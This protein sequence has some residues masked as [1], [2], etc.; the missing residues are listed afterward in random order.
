[1]F[2]YVWLVLIFLLG[3]C[4]GS[5]LNVCIFRLPWEKNVLWPG[6]HCGSCFQAI[7]WYDNLPILSWLLLRG[8]CRRCGAPFSFRYLFIELFTGLSFSGMFYLIAIVN[9]HDFQQ[10]QN[11]AWSLGNGWPPPA[12][13]WV[14]FFH[15]AC[16]ISFLIVASFC[17]LDHQE[18]PF[19]I[20]I[21]G[22]A[23]GLVWAVFL[24]WP[25]PYA[26]E[27]PPRGNLPPWWSAPVQRPLAFDPLVEP[28]AQAPLDEG[29][30]TGYYAWPVWGPPLFAWVPPRGWLMGLV[31]GVAGAAVGWIMLWLVRFLFTKGLGVEAMGLGDADLMMMAGAFLGWQP[32]VLAFFLS[33]FPG[34]LFGIGTL[35]L[36]GE[37]ALPFGP[38]LALGTVVVLLGWHWI[39]PRFQ[40][41]LFD[42][43]LLLVL[44]GF[45][46]IMMFV[47]SALLR[48]TR[49]EPA[50]DEGGST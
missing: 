38:S 50:A 28:W 17:D 46:S 3:L 36:R 26:M 47:L 23:V 27:R 8:R 44:G 49:R 18:I 20:T 32:V 9:I 16:L 22:T 21:P 1:M 25:A 37:R 6:S 2:V 29:P 48:F 24:P 45:G 31:T 14:A 43:V 10:L 41:L 13:V 4:V 15:H 33:V 30:R 35:L 5:F 7:R 40:M 12:V 34:L 39:G 19:S 42:P 11:L